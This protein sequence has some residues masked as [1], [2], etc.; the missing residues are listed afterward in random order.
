MYAYLSIQNCENSKHHS[1]VRS[2][3]SI[4]KPFELFEWNFV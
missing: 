1:S 2:Y 3:D 4:P